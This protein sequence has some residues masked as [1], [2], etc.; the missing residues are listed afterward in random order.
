MVAVSKRCCVSVIR[1]AVV[2]GRYRVPPIGK[3][4]QSFVLRSSSERETEKPHRN[5][6]PWKG[7][8]FETRRIK[9]KPLPNIETAEKLLCIHGQEERRGRPSRRQRAASFFETTASLL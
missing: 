9:T 6:A 7:K 1:K 4:E 8:E 3:S 2:D 5:I